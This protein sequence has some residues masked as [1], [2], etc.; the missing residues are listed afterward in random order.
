MRAVA[1]VAETEAERLKDEY[2][3]TEHLLLALTLEGDLAP[4]AQLLS[5]QGVTTDRV[6]EAL[7]A[8]RGGQRV[9]NQHPEGKG[10]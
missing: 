2:V 7:S 10:M 4:S 8:I 6:L 9:T 3:S 1:S 5:R